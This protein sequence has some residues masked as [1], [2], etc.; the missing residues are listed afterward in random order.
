MADHNP[1]TPAPPPESWNRLTPPSQVSPTADALR[2]AVQSFEPVTDVARQQVLQAIA[3][4]MRAAVDA[5]TQSAAHVI[6][7]ALGKE[8]QTVAAQAQPRREHRP[9]QTVSPTRKA[10]RP[11]PRVAPA[12]ITGLVIIALAIGGLVLV[13]ALAGGNNSDPAGDVI[14]DITPDPSSGHVGEVV[15]ATHSRG[16][17][18]ITVHR[19]YLSDTNGGM[20]SVHDGMFL[21]VD[22]EWETVAGDDHVSWI[23]IE[24]FY[25]DG[26]EAQQNIM[27]TDLLQ[28]SLQ[29]AG[30]VTAGSV[31]FEVTEAGPY[32]VV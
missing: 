5:Q 8:A 20:A 11:R 13:T 27:V 6:R 26:T 19:T 14:V 25:P 16:E 31:S 10:K 28:T 2:T 30:D 15:H 4:A 17:S 22:L 3:K 12:L 32:T 24:A 9:A 23:F 7:K 29:N 18:I 1:L 21:I